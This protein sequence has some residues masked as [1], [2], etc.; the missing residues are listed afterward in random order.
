[1]ECF[2]ELQLEEFSCTAEGKIEYGVDIHK[3][4]EDA[5]NV[6]WRYGVFAF[7]K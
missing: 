1:M 5:H 3:Y 4:D 6:E 2:H 7:V